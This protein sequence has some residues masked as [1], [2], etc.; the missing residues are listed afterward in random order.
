MNKGILED[1][2]FSST[3]ASLVILQVAWTYNSLVIVFLEFCD[4][5]FRP[6]GR[7]QNNIV[8]ELEEIRTSIFIC[9]L[10][11]TIPS[12]SRSVPTIT[13]NH[14]GPWYLVCM[15]QKEHIIIVYSYV[16]YILVSLALGCFKRR[17]EC[18]M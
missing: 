15:F 8:C 11:Q 7:F 9:S 4:E 6:T 14:N 17:H 10:K 12:T 5:S 18:R 3:F 16:E 13:K 2:R 1:E